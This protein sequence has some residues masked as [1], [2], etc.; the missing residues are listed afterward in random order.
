MAENEVKLT[1]VKRYNIVL[2]DETRRK[3]EAL[4]VAE[5]RSF[6]NLLAV[7]VTKEFERRKLELPTPPA[8]SGE[9]SVAA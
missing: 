6:S 3:G 5:M 4:A 9:R 2:D 8:G 1:E 7:L